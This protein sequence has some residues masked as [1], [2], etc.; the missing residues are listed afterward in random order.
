MANL[1]QPAG[2]FTVDRT[3]HDADSGIHRMVRMAR[4]KVTGRGFGLQFRVVCALYG[5]H[6]S[7]AMHTVGV[8]HYVAAIDLRM[9]L[10]ED[11]E[12]LAGGLGA[13]CGPHRVQQLECDWVETQ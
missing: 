12:H 4:S 7:H 11:A 9:N 8:E 6:P 10:D 2:C 3:G 13:A 5:Q 1:L